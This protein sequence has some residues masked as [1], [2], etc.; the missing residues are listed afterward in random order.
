V[1]EASAPGA[2]LVG[3]L[4]VK[5]ATLSTGISLRDDHLRNEYLEVGKADGFDR[6]VLSEI[7]LGDVDLHTF[8]GRTKFTA[9]LALHGQQRPVS[10]DAEVRRDP[11]STRVLAS[12]PVALEDYGIAKPQYLG[13]GVKS[14][15][16][17]KVSLVAVRVGSPN[18]GS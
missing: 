12:F 18:G 5:L 8:Q 10:G 2:A 17:V 16:Q 7:R 9:T 15:V 1:A 14:E 6:A 13:V 3:E 4:T 11:G